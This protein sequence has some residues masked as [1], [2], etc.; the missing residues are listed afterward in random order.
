MVNSHSMELIEREVECYTG[1]LE[2]GKLV[3]VDV[4]VVQK[5]G[6]EKERVL[7][8]RRVGLGKPS[9]EI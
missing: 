9:G 1:T 6:Q 8:G 3:G 4:G 5:H 2:R 7:A